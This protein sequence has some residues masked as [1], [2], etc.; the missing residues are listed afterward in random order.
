MKK[1]PNDNEFKKLKELAKQNRLIFS[2]HFSDIRSDERDITNEEVKRVIVRGLIF[3]EDN[4]YKSVCKVG[5]KYL[6]AVFHV[7]PKDYLFIITAY[8]PESNSWDVD[9][10]KNWIRQRRQ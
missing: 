6:S 9:S 3:E 7:T 5:N 4:A 8:N 1:I 10:Y 2:K